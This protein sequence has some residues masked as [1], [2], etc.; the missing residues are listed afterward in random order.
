MEPN[1]KVLKQ[2]KLQEATDEAAA[3]REFKAYVHTNRRRALYLATS[4]AQELG[5][6]SPFASA[7]A[8]IKRDYQNIKRVVAERP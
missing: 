4:G 2:I 5:F 6:E 7:P 1:R 3:V 8:K